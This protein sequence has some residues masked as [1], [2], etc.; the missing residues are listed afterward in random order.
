VESDTDPRNYSK[1][2]IRHHVGYIRDPPLWKYAESGAF[3]IIRHLTAFLCDNLLVKVA[4]DP[5]EKYCARCQP[6]NGDPHRV[7]MCFMRKDGWHC[8]FVEADVKTLSPKKLTFEH[9]QEIIELA[10]RGG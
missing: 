1:I 10:E 6:G 2:A 3:A 4:D 9:P 5:R 8:Q 7:Y